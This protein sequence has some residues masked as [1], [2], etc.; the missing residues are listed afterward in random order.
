MVFQISG[1][2]KLLSVPVCLALG[3]S[4]SYLMSAVTLHEIFQLGE[5]IS[6]L[7]MTIAQRKAWITKGGKSISV[8]AFSQA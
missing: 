6:G 1:A 4:N 5:K 3:P 7:V 2:L 8:H